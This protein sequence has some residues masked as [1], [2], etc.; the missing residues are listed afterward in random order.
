MGRVDTMI[1]YVPASKKGT[2]HYQICPCQFTALDIMSALRI[3]L[4]KKY[5]DFSC[6]KCKRKFTVVVDD[7]KEK[8]NE[9]H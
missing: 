4:D 6:P 1:C 5:N 3:R 8:T 2:A 9:L 7:N